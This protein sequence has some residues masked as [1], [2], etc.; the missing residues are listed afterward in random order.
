MADELH[1]RFADM[2]SSASQ[3]TQWANE[4]AGIFASGHKEIEDAASGWVG[5]S[6]AAL[7]GALEKLHS[8]ANALTGNL[9]NHS[10]HI[11]TAATELHR[12]DSEWRDQLNQYVDEPGRSSLDL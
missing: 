5:S 2:R 1:A 8:S 4:S 12:T 3:L 9:D 11:H 7:S 6:A 10:T